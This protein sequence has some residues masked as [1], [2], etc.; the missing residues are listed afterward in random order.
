MTRREIE[1][2]KNI[3]EENELPEWMKKCLCCKH[4]YEKQNDCGTIYCRLRTGKCK[5]EEYKPMK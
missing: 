1:K 3:D 4:S 2:Q 5:Y